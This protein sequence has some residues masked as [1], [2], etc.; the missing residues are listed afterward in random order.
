MLMIGFDIANNFINFIIKARRW[1]KVHC[2]RS[3]RSHSPY[4]TSCP[5]SLLLIPYTSPLTLHKNMHPLAQDMLPVKISMLLWW[6]P[7]HAPWVWNKSNR[8][9]Q[10]W[11]NLITKRMTMHAPKLESVSGMI[12][13][14]PIAY[15]SS[16]SWRWALQ[17]GPTSPTK[18]V[19]GS[20]TIPST[21]K[22]PKI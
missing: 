16:R 6:H 15:P 10:F 8:N 22:S 19:A 20:T 4:R 14:L 7:R 3:L 21:L 11:K 2:P 13:S 9:S 5:N 1:R 17:T 12:F 18:P